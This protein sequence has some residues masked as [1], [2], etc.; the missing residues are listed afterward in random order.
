M[1]ANNTPR[2]PNDL[3][4]AIPNNPFFSPRA[5][6]PYLEGAFSPIIVGCGLEVCGDYINS[7]AGVAPIPV[8]LLSQRG[9]L[10]SAVGPLDPAELPLGD[11]G[12]YLTVDSSTPTGLK[13]EFPPDAVGCVSCTAFTNKGDILAAEQFGEPIA[14]PIGNP[15][16]YLSVNPSTPTGLEWVSQGF[17][18]F[19][20]KGQILVSCSADCALTIS[21]R[22]G[23][24]LMYFGGSPTGW[25]A[26]QGDEFFVPQCGFERGW[27]VVGCDQCKSTFLPAGPPN[28][29]LM[30]DSNCQIGMKWKCASQKPIQTDNI[31][32][33]VP[34]SCALGITSLLPG[35][36]YF[37][38]CTVFVA[39]TGA[40]YG[41]QDFA[42]A[43]ICLQQGDDYSCP[44]GF[45]NN[46]NS[47]QRY[48][49]GISYIFSS[50]CGL[51]GCDLQLRVS[52]PYGKDICITTQVSAFI[53][54]S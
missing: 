52:N 39:V 45:N 25:C 2:I 32:T 29:V 12:Q 23:D 20:G 54:R 5:H 44:T 17:Q 40:W 26:V 9:S 48:P 1:P 43:E 51:Y 22:H 33:N 42:E 11:P 41:D 30:T 13:W 34:A 53:I 4:Q 7:Q 47:C 14:L 15:G 21:G 50:W 37:Q 18:P 8:E 19:T 31:Y 6:V 46:T 49:F 38:D 3:N 27:L 28:S 10:I 36:T 16:D 24:I 35:N